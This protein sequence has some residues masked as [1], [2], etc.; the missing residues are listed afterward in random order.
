M[1]RRSRC[2][3]SVVSR[4][5]SYS[6]NSRRDILLQ[7]GRRCW[8]VRWKGVGFARHAE[9]PA[10]AGEGAETGA[11]PGERNRRCVPLLPARRS[12]AAAR[13][14]ES[15]EGAER[16][17]G[18]WESVRLDGA[19]APSPKAA[20]ASY[21]APRPRGCRVR[22]DGGGTAPLGAAAEAG[23]AELPAAASVGAG[24]VWGAREAKCCRRGRAEF[25][26][27]GMRCV[28][29]VNAGWR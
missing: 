28:F 26:A 27:Q 14:A 4:P 7:W 17:G 13:S 6:T 15:S 3:V 20:G 8:G 5:E 29:R 25:L 12:A 10:A 2:Q 1:S 9:D 19:Q 24:D 22:G 23:A 21:P 18:L 11:G 16:L